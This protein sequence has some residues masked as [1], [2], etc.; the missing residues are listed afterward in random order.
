[1]YILDGFIKKN[2]KYCEFIENYFSS[3]QRRMT[4]KYVFKESGMG[5]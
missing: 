5:L 4:Q 1:M 3:G 2:V